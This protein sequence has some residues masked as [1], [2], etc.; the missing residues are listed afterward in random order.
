MLAISGAAYLSVIITAGVIIEKLIKNAKKAT[1][2]TFF[3]GL[4]QVGRLGAHRHCIA[5][6][7]TG[8]ASPKV[9][10]MVSSARPLYL[11]TPLCR[12]H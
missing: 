7:G 11:D 6:V 9:L 12:G 4:E 10:H 1:A 2:P 5:G 3:W 8:P